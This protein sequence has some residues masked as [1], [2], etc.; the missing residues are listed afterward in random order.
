MDD[1]R[2]DYSK[3][4]PA[5]TRM[6]LPDVS[7]EQELLNT[8]VPFAHRIEFLSEYEKFNSKPMTTQALS[9]ALGVSET[10]VEIMAFQLGAA[11]SVDQNNNRV[12]EEY[13]FAVMQDEVS[14]QKEYDKLEEFLS[15]S[16]IG[17]FLLKSEQ[18]VK[19][20]AAGLGIYPESKK[21][22][23]NRIVYVYPK[24]LIGMLRTII[25]HTPPANDFHNTDEVEAIV[26]KE[27]KWIE[28]MVR[29]HNLTYEIR[30]LTLAQKPG[31]HYPQETIDALM[32]IRAELPPPA[33]DWLTL[34]QIRKSI[35]RSLNWIDEYLG[36]YKT[37]G[38]I[39]LTDSERVAI[40]YSPETLR[41]LQDIIANLPPPAEDWMTE[42]M[43]AHELGRTKQWVKERLAPYDTL[44]EIRLTNKGNRTYVHYPPTVLTALKKL[45]DEEIKEAQGWIN[46]NEISD[47]LL[48]SR[49]W[50]KRRIGSIGVASEIRLDRK[51]QPRTHYPPEIVDV[52]QLNYL[53]DEENA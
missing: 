18:W 2:L 50:I 34:G 47:M 43:L 19:Q 29:E 33:G 13:A 49:F 41:H 11:F 51:R 38:E 23:E 14:W 22:G 46:E 31:V 24:S 32:L 52:F 5:E 48:K 8:P 3:P 27:R 6:E 15:G 53:I 28:K 25:Y 36:E 10:R 45:I 7:Y 9:A 20:N 40:H 42:S 4:F 17:S 44:S 37:T 30:M 12:Y 39:R 1:L 21:I 35:S 26:G 16:S